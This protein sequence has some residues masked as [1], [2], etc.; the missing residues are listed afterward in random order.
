MTPVCAHRNLLASLS[1]LLLAAC[2]SS[3]STTEVRGKTAAERTKMVYGG[4]NG[5]ASE[6]EVVLAAQEGSP[7]GQVVCGLATTDP[8]GGPLY[9]YRGIPYADP[10]TASYRWTDPR[11]PTYPEIPAT[12]YGPRCPQGSAKALPLLGT[13]VNEDCLYLNVWT[14]KVTQQGG[15][16][17]PVMVFIHGGAFIMGS[18][19]WAQGTQ[20]GHLNLYD[21][22]QFVATSRTPGPPVVFV[23]MNY[24]LG[25]LGFLAGDQIG[26]SGN[27]GIKDQTAALQWVQRNISRFGGDPAKVMIF[28]ESAGA[29]STA[30]H[31]TIQ[32]GGH[33]DL[34]ARAAMESSYAISYQT[35]EEA[36]G[37]ADAFAL[38][39]GCRGAGGPAAVGC[40]QSLPLA[41]ILELQDF[42]AEHDTLCNG[43]QA[44]LPW[45][46]VVDHAFITGE[47]IDG[48]VTKPVLLG[49]NLN[50]SIPFVAPWF[51]AEPKA[52][53]V[54]YPA[55]VAFLFGD[56]TAAAVSVE[57]QAAFPTF[58]PEQKMEQVVTDYLWTCF[59]RAFAAVPAASGQPVWRYHNVHHGSFSVWTNPTKETQSKTATACATSPAVCHADELPFVF[60]NPTDDK[61]ILQTF[62]PDEVSLSLAIRNYWIQFARTGNPNVAGQPAWPPHGSGQVLQLQA[63]ASAISAVTDPASAVST[64]CGL[65]WDPVGYKVKSAYASKPEC[66]TP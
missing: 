14:P 32:Q 10:P 25:V 1:L 27:Y 20:P 26:L 38:A 42:P 28:G 55:A 46:P 52:A 50:E 41:T 33:Q 11:P 40:L 4:P 2:S 12:E 31:L 18:G 45:Q 66:A 22:A 3:Q 44:L 13:D 37:K 34:F 58:A 29:Q 54:A 49:S 21:G 63:P 61:S 43:L 23:T 35:V 64:F 36:Q 7:P 62:T 17:L 5:C 30:L 15:G 51:P 48:P 24:R 56:V 16:D 60:G 9:L 8:A 39:T 19:G 47:P 6:S 59:N 65:I 53:A 57:Y